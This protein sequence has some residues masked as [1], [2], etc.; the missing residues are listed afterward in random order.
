VLAFALVAVPRVLPD[1]ALRTPPAA[2]HLI[3]SLLTLVFSFAA[4]HPNADVAAYLKL[5]LF[6]AFLSILKGG[7]VF[8]S[9]FAFEFIAPL[10]SHLEWR[11]G[12][13]RASTLALIRAYLRTF[14]DSVREWRKLSV[15]AQ[16]ATLL[17]ML[18][19]LTV[20]DA[21][22][23]NLARPQ[24]IQ[25]LTITDEAVEGARRPPPVLLLREAPR[26]TF[27][28]VPRDR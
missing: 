13:L 16:H 2:V 7:G 3:F 9:V 15:A 17:K 23:H 5:V 20:I 28:C 12:D 27:M 8:G 22:T 25:E 19:D 6:P 14:E 1:G 11:A 10:L 18:F 24:P 26:G 21:A 4:A